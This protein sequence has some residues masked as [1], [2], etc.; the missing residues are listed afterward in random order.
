MAAGSIHNGDHRFSAV[1]GEN[2]CVRLHD[3]HFHGLGKILLFGTDPKYFLLDVTDQFFKFGKFLPDAAFC[4]RKVFLLFLQFF[5]CRFQSI[6][7]FQDPGFNSGNLFFQ[8]GDLIHQCLILGLFLDKR[9][10]GQRLLLFFPEGGTFPF[11]L[12]HIQ[13]QTFELRLGISHSLFGS[14]ILFFQFG[15]LA[16]NGFIFHFQRTQFHIALLDGQDPRHP[17]FHSFPFPSLRAF[18]KTG[19]TC[20][21][22]RKNPRSLG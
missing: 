6:H 20:L 16:G 17:R 22:I 18:F 1:S 5:S 13:F 19:R 15:T 2:I 7:Q 3:P 10:L 12:F 8:M 14:Q 4:Q 21:Y 11:G 9:R